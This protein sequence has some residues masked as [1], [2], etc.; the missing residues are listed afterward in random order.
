MCAQWESTI[1]STRPIVDD[2]Y[3]TR[4]KYFYPSSYSP[5]SMSIAK[6]MGLLY[7]YIVGLMII[8]GVSHG[9]GYNCGSGQ[10]IN[11]ETDIKAH[12]VWSNSL[13]KLGSEKVN[14]RDAHKKLRGCAASPFIFPLPSSALLFLLSLFPHLLP[15]TAKESMGALSA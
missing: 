6:A 12:C 10:V 15:A 13:C 14:G 8:V 4:S 9:Y 7:L 3:S 2:A 1:S 5:T 11:N